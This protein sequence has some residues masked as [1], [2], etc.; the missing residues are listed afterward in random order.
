MIISLFFFILFFCRCLAIDLD[1]WEQFDYNVTHLAIN[2]QRMMKTGFVAAVSIGHPL[3]SWSLTTQSWTLETGIGAAGVQVALTTDYAFARDL[4]DALRIQSF[5]NTDFNFFT[6]AKDIKSG[7]GNNVVYVKNT[8]Y[9]PGNFEIE[10]L[11]VDT[12]T[13]MSSFQGAVRVSMASGAMWIIKGDGFI[14]EVVSGV[15]DNK[16]ETAKDI[17][18]GN[19]DIPYIVSE[20]SANDGFI[21]KKWDALNNNWDVVPGISG[22][23]VALDSAN[24]PYVITNGNKAFRKRGIMYSFCPGKK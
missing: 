14:Y 4:T 19:D 20:E 1:I 22:V 13:A 24:N 23:S 12:Q 8:L 21:I 15:L 17:I 16:L 11:D 10:F 7:S 2:G 6:T 9:S 3:Y 5:P 18:V